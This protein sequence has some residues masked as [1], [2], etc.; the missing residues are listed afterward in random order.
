MRH[1]TEPALLLIGVLSFNHSGRLERRQYIRA[2][3]PPHHDAV[4]RFVMA[5]DEAEMDASAGDVLLL[6]LGTNRSQHISLSF[7]GT[8]GK[9]LL[10][11]AFFRWVVQKQFRKFRFVAR[12][13]DDTLVSVPMIVG[14]LN[15]VPTHETVVYGPFGEWYWWL[16]GDP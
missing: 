7:R 4:L 11:N 2:L 9:L 8:V 12:A 15:R 16:P 14:Q 10:Q 1:P 5:E 3:T 6:R 13:D